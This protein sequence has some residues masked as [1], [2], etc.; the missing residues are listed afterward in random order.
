MEK[1]K[2]FGTLCKSVTLLQSTDL[3]RK[4]YEVQGNVM[5]HSVKYFVNAVDKVFGG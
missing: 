4:L 1:G 5:A 2:K 3:L